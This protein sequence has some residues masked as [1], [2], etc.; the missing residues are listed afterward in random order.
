MDKSGKWSLFINF[1]QIFVFG[2]ISKFQYYTVKNDLML[3]EKWH[4]P[5]SSF[6]IQINT[7]N[8]QIFAHFNQTISK[9]YLHQN[10]EAFAILMKMSKTLK[11][12]VIFKFSCAKFL[13]TVQ[14]LSSLIFSLIFC[15]TVRK[16]TPKIIL[17]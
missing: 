6:K 4:F 10:R 15:R 1:D 5:H 7:S 11:Q 9:I 12:I 17:Y 13:I 8:Y 3:E 2:F 16:I 14:M